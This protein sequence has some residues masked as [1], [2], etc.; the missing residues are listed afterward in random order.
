MTE[1]TSPVAPWST[2]LTS[3]HVL[4]LVLGLFVV[5]FWPTLSLLN[6]RWQSS[7]SAYSHG[8][9]LVIVV[10][11]LI[12]LR[13][14]RITREPPRPSLTAAFLTLGG[15]LTWWLAESVQVLV[16]QQAV[17]P[18]LIFLLVTSLLGW[19][20]ARHVAYPL[21]LLYL[22]VP[23]WDVLVPSFQS[24][25]SAV[26]GGTVRSLGIKVFIDGSIITIPEGTFE[27]AY[28]CSGLAFFMAAITLGLVYGCLYCTKIS[29]RIFVACLFAAVGVVS[30]WVRIL[31]VVLAGHY[32]QM[33]SRLIHDHWDLGWWI[34]AIASI[35]SLYLAHRMTSTMPMPQ[36][37]E[38]HSRHPRYA[39]ST[40]EILWPS[41]VLMVALSI[42]AIAALLYPN[43][44]DEALRVKL[45]HF[46]G[47][48]STDN[49]ELSARWSPAFEGADL[50]L[51]KPYPSTATPVSLHVIWYGTQ[52][53][54]RKLTRDGNLIADG[55]RWH[56]DRE[57]AQS[58]FPN[59]NEAFAKANKVTLISP[60][61]QR[62]RVWYWYL[63]GSRITGGVVDLKI[64][65]M[66]SLL[67]G[68]VDGAL[69][70]LSAECAE[71]S[72]ADATRSLGT[73]APHALHDTTSALTTE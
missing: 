14:P 72:C 48:T 20:S 13:W 69:V 71:R 38:R 62:L 56:I 21:A 47:A 67:E 63:V 61:G 27:I 17:L 28:S 6:Q 53:Q 43:E 66:Q 32:T 45:L 41:L 25:A 73:I 55:V 34:F 5:A 10:C 9:L 58:S 1:S 64:R 57:F 51:T 23:I 68:R 40:N 22:V 31:V 16:V 59:E 49:D 12:Y 8:P 11:Y 50:S 4:V 26:V 30:N 29:H 37:H 54:Q 2:R 19:R 52:S 33:H 15:A 18:A 44:P 36:A 70:A 35:P 60:Q 24:I 3:S 7:G 65:Q 39:A 46:A 42:P